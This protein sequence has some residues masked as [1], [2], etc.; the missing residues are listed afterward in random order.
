MIDIME[1]EAII[2]WVYHNQELVI[3]FGAI[4][5]AFGTLYQPTRD[6]LRA[7]PRLLWNVIKF[8]FRFIWFTAW[9]ARKL[10]AVLYEK[11]A[12]KHGEAF[13]D[14]IFEWFEKREQGVSL[15]RKVNLA[16]G[17]T[18]AQSLLVHF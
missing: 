2:N 11:F 15:L 9:P 18:T 10:I 13:F 7:L 6:L 1:L 16:I 8:S 14:R 17:T 12:A 5:T 4:A 3:A